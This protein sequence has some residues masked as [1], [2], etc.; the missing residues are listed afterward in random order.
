MRIEDLMELRTKKEPLLP[1]LVPYLQTVAKSNLMLNAPLVQELFIE[2]GCFAFC[3]LR[4]LHKKQ[5]AK[6]ALEASNYHRYVFL[7]ERPYRF[8]AFIK[9][10]KMLRRPTYWKLLRGVWDDSENIWQHRAS[11]KRLL[12]DNDCLRG[13]LMSRAERAFLKSLPQQIQ[14]YRGQKKKHHRGMSW[15]LYREKAEWF[16]ARLKRKT[17]TAIILEGIADKYDVIAY[18][19]GRGEDEIIVPFNR[20]KNQ[21]ARVVP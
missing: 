2:D 12:T 17:E 1:E 18:L 16:A 7:H 14:V 4:Y 21:V 20:V 13:L 10:H 5:A 3:N 9:I 15:T 11:W 6:D 19:E 8:E